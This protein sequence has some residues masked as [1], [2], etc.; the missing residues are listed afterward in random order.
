MYLNVL[1]STG[2]SLH[3]I[4][5]T[6]RLRKS[7]KLDCG[8]WL[9]FDTKE[10]LFS[11]TVMKALLSDVLKHGDEKAFVSEHSPILESQSSEVLVEPHTLTIG[12]DPEFF[13]RDLTTGRIAEAHRFFPHEG[14][15]GSDGDLAEFRPDFALCPDQLTLNIKEL[16]KKLHSS[17]P[18][19]IEPLAES[20]NFR[21]CCGFHVHLGMPIEL[22]SFA[23]DQ[24]DKFFKNV[25]ST[26]DYLVGVP[27][28]ALDRVDSRR[29]SW[30]Y[31]RPGDY[32]LNMRTLEYRTPGGFHLKTPA[33][34]RNLLSI[35]FKVMDRIIKEAE[36]ISGGWVD[37][38]NVAKFD[39]FKSKYNIPDKQDIKQILLSK[40]RNR[41]EEE[42]KKVHAILPSIVA[43][44]SKN[45]ITERSENDTP[46]FEKWLKDETK[47]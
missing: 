15:V 34:T 36:E 26:I 2:T 27:A 32:R 19:F 39:Y 9:F 40:G 16:I 13:L 24:T 47:H 17:L 10:G 45:I 3:Q 25:V 11:V 33:Y 42:S 23:A 41:L 4:R 38:S 44:Y 29:F 21:R 46:F 8:D 20:F 22:L 1:P 43:E 18:I 37:M 35:T 30:E 12:C 5:M 6:E 7:L 31:G 14:Q 28:A